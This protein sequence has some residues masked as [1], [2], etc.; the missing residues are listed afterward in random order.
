MDRTAVR[1]V[2]AGIVAALAY[3]GTQLDQSARFAIGAIAGLP[4]C[5]LMIVSRRQLGDSFSIRPEAKTLITT[6]LY[7]RILHPM[8]FFLDLFLI[9]LIVTLG[10]PL[11][12]LAWAGLVLLQTFQARHEENVL[13]A[14][15]G[16]KYEEYRRKTWF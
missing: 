6:G 9:A 13:I 10:V 14:V 15:F 4:S 5:A 2:S 8:Y 16:I 7:S 12:L 1:L 11:P 3:G